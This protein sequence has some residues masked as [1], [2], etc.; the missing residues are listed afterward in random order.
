MRRSMKFVLGTLAFIAPLAIAQTAHAG[1]DACGD[2]HVEAEAECSV[3][4]GIECEGMCTPLSVEAQCAADLTIEC[5]GECEG[6]LSVSAECSGS[7]EADCTAECEVEPAEFNCR[8]Q[9]NSDCQARA[10][11][12]CGDSEC[13]AQAEASCEAEC[14][15]AC[16]VEP[17]SADCE[18]TC[19]GSCEASCEASGE[20]YLDCQAECQGPSFSDCQAEIEGGCEVACESEEGAIFC[21]GS[22]IDHDGNLEECVSSIE[23][24][25]RARVEINYG[26]EASCSGNECE[27]SGFFNCSCSADPEQRGRDTMLLAFGA[28]FVFGVARRRRRAA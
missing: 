23:A 20:A 21:D 5:R 16:E 3:E 25:I 24:W 26:G 2:I 12:R 28:L 4:G 8:A 10:E 1:L 7:C 15:G 17:G 19:Q 27:A 11:G 14:S 18:A 13:F 22:Y 9:C 6:E